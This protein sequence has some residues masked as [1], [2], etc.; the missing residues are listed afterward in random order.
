MIR[1]PP[2]RMTVSMGALSE[3]LRKFRCF[4]AGEALASEVTAAA[5]A[6]YLRP[7]FDC[8]QWLT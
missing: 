7:G 4:D 8:P 3:L 1:Q 6:A 2:I 5:S